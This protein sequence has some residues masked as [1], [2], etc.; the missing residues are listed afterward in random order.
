ML[1]IT[2]QYPP[3]ASSGVFRTIRFIENLPQFGWNPVV[4]TVEPKF[5]DESVP[6][7]Y[8]ILSKSKQ[9]NEIAVYRSK[10][11]PT[12]DK[13]IS[14]VR[15]LIRRKKDIKA[16]SFLKNH[17]AQK[18]A[19]YKTKWQQFKDALTISLRVP[20]KQN[21]WIL[22]AIIKGLLVIKKE[23]PKVIYAT[24]GPWS[25]FII[26]TIL[27][28]IT[29][30]PLII[31]FRDP[32]I[33]N[34]YDKLHSSIRSSLNKFLEK[35]CVQTADYVIANTEPLRRALMHRYAANCITQQF[36]TILNSFNES[37]FE[38]IKIKK[39]KKALDSS[40]IVSH[41]G[42]LY[43]NRSPVN[44]IYALSA[45]LKRGLI[46]KNDIVIKFIGNVQ[47][48]GLKR[49]IEDEKLTRIVKFT[50]YVSKHESLKMSMESDILLLIQ[51]ETMLQI[52]AK[53]FEYIRTGNS[54]FTICDEGATEEFI[55]S[56]NL[57]A[58]ARYND[59]HEISQEFV[60]IYRET[61]E[62]IQLKSKRSGID[63]G[64]IKK[65]DSKNMTRQLVDLLEKYGK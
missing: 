53:I 25:S 30:L 41:I 58:V 6:I 44:F 50:G 59:I 29:R 60:N 4:L 5:Y 7:D 55:L 31:D 22:F 36:V 37:E 23:K 48:P 24:G 1:F 46:D 3:C 52:P 17:P 64:I 38:N 9:L 14:L 10:A 2:Y 57:G 33:D 40:V 42:T 47:V 12:I 56:N 21:T 62:K 49:I 28:K 16:S 13:I 54:I 18:F 65:F 8:N 27:A 43:A 20:D 11:L 39:D 63:K 45:L 51:P 32:W 61:L 35:K 19:L 15:K 34:P 26:G